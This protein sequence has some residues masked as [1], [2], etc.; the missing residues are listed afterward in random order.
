MNAEQERNNAF[1]IPPDQRPDVIARWADANQ[2]L[3]SGLL[4]NGASIA[5]HAAV[6]DAHYGKG[7]VVL[8][9]NNPMWR[10]ET[11]G[12]Y[13]MLLNAIVNYDRLH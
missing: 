1:L 9:A 12:S 8:F 5:Q 3:I 6:V 2:L 11:V 13:A 7:N 10:G 4:E